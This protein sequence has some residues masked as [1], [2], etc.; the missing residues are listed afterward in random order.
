MIT[1]DD[2]ASLKKILKCI[3]CCVALHNLLLE[4]NDD[5][6]EESIDDIRDFTEDDLDNGLGA[7]IQLGL[8]KDERRQR[9]MECFRDFA[10]QSF[11]A[12]L[13]EIKQ[14]DVL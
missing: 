3:D 13:I 10:V 8:A 9:L 4:M 1:T 11:N 6:P 7:P 14:H 5:F 2:K 12:T